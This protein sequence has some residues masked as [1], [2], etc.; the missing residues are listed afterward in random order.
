MRKKRGLTI[1]ERAIIAVPAFEQ[2]QQKLQQQVVLCNQSQSTL[3]N[4]I[5]RIALFVLHFEKLPEEILI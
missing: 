2:V 4:Y 1:V 3:K 5:R